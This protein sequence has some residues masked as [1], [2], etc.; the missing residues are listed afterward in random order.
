MYSPIPGCA[1][2]EF[3][4]KTFLAMMFLLSLNVGF[5]VRD[6]GLANAEGTVRH[7]PVEFLRRGMDFV[8]PSAASALD[9]PYYVGGGDGLMKIGEELDMILHSANFD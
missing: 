9:V 1:P 2:P 5:D 7:L 3:I 6:C 8:E 4:L